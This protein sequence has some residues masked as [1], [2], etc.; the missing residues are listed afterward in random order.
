MNI[1]ECAVIKNMVGGGGGGASEE[2][3]ARIADLEARVDALEPG[4]LFNIEA[5][6]EENPDARIIMDDG[7]IAVLS[8]RHVGSAN[9]NVLPD[10]IDGKTY[11]FSCNVEQVGDIWWSA[12]PPTATCG[13]NCDTATVLGDRII[14]TFV[15]TKPNGIHFDVA[16]G[17]VWVD[18][19]EYE[20]GGYYEY[21][22]VP[23]IYYNIM[24][25]EGTKPMP[26][27]PYKG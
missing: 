9:A 3:L 6:L 24:V 13:D 20:S 2:L 7:Q 22:P 21:C 11:T 1:F 5:F 15:A 12:N 27:K 10:L 23:V 18:D 19:P 8:D 17:E 14:F 26:Y 16:Q 25:N 4:N